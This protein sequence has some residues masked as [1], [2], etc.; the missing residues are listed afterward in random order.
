MALKSDVSYS[1]FPDDMSVGLSECQMEADDVTEAHVL[2]GTPVDM[3][4]LTVDHT[5]SLDESNR[6]SMA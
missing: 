2:D 6:V 4:Q 5:E 3:S 1:F